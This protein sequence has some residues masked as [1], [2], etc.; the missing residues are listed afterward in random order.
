MGTSDIFRHI[1]SSTM[2]PKLVVFLAC[3]AAASAGVIPLHPHPVV[4]HPV[5]HVHPVHPHPQPVHPV[6]PHRHPVHPIH[7]PKHE[8]VVDK[9]DVFP[10][11]PHP[12]HPVG[13]HPVV[14]HP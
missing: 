7:V 6:H 13:H 12:A 8:V 9:H 5:K 2:E 4:H 10:V 1:S 11:K 14:H 3:M